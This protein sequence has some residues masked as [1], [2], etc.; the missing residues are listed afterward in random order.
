[1]EGNG[2]L[3]LSCYEAISTHALNVA[4]RQAHYLNLEAVAHNVASDNDMEEELIQYAKSCAQPGVTYYFN[5][6]ATSMKEPFEAWLQD[7]SAQLKSSNL[8]QVSQHLTLYQFSLVYIL[9][10]SCS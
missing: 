1:M 2:L 7:F 10:N 5:Q 3:A 6:L 8:C 4:A 9:L